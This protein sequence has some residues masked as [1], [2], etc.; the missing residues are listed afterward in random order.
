MP[1]HLIVANSRPIVLEG[2]EHLFRQDEGFQL[3]A[4]C[5]DG[6]ETMEA[7]RRH[8]PDVL[9]LDLHMPGK[10][11]LAI[12]REVRAEKIPARVILFTAELDEKQL[13]EAVYAGVQ[14]I[15]LIETR[16]QLLVQ[17]VRKVHA[18]EHWFDR[19]STQ[20]AIERMLQREAGA[21]EMAGS[22]TPQEIKIIMLTAQGLRNKEIASSLSITEGTV[23]GHL[24]NIYDKLQ[25]AGRPA[26]LRYAQQRGLV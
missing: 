21:Y 16:S 5:T 10:D 24:H 4:R 20:A 23:K 22:A 3:M 13:L 15:V 7:V 6:L 26:L 9:V 1:I 18:G 17:C 2:M 8:R 19:S 11:G 12:S 25:L 14:G